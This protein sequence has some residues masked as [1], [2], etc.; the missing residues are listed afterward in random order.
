MATLE[1]AGSPAS[2][3][4]LSIEGTLILRPIAIMVAIPAPVRCCCPVFLD[5]RDFLATQPLGIFG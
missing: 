5:S 3:H 1:G 2:C 4:L